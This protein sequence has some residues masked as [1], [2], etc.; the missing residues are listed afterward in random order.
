MTCLRPQD[1]LEMKIKDSLLK[2]KLAFSI[3]PQERTLILILMSETG[4]LFLSFVM[5]LTE[6]IIQECILIYSFNKTL[7]IRLKAPQTP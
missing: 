4:F 7:Q 5:F 6:Q 2:A 3:C 1:L